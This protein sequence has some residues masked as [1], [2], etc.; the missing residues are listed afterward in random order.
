MWTLVSGSI[1][2]SNG[3]GR[4]GGVVAEAVSQSP[5]LPASPRAHASRLACPPPPS[6]LAGGT[7]RDGA[8]CRAR[9][10]P[11]RQFPRGQPCGPM[12][13]ARCGRVR[14]VAPSGVCI[15]W[16][17]ETITARCLFAATGASD[18][19]QR[20]RWQGLCA[21]A[22]DRYAVSQPPAGEVCPLPSF[23]SPPANSPNS[24]RSP[25]KLPTI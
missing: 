4:L 17:L 1:M 21:V 12:G 16:Q 20:R 15:R 7:G 3:V 10:R 23:S 19:G 8:N 22:T 14:S 25:R 11:G 24:F 6:S 2:A 5:A 9:V 13:A 18:D